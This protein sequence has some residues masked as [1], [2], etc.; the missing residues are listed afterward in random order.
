VY[1]VWLNLLWLTYEVLTFNWECTLVNSEN[2]NKLIGNLHWLICKS[3]MVI[4]WEIIFR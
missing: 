2:D 1:I 3:T 4:N